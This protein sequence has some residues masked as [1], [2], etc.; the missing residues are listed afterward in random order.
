M[1]SY[2]WSSSTLPA[3]PKMSRVATLGFVH[4]GFGVCGGGGGG[5]PN[6]CSGG[7]K[8]GG[9]GGMAGLEIKYS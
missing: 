2:I 4:F 9:G 3:S 1:V 6:F 5:E 8:G 7:S